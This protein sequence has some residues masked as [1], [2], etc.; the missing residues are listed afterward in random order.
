MQLFGLLSVLASL[1]FHPSGY[2]WDVGKSS[3]D[4]VSVEIS[5]H[6]FA[7]PFTYDASSKNWYMSG[8]TIPVKRSRSSVILNP[9][10]RQKFGFMFNKKRMKSNNFDVSILLHLDS[11][12]PEILNSSSPEPPV[13]QTFGIWFSTKADVAGLMEEH[14]NSVFKA[15]TSKSPASFT[16]VL[17]SAQFDKMTIVPKHFAGVGAVVSASD[18]KYQKEFSAT[19]VHADGSEK[20]EGLRSFPDASSAHLFNTTKNSGNSYKKYYLSYMRLRLLVRPDSV[21]LRIQDGLDWRTV[22]KKEGIDTKIGPDGGYIGITSWTGTSGG[23]P[24]GIR[25]SSV[26][27]NS[28]DFRTLASDPGNVA[29]DLFSNEGLS[30]ERL[31]SED[32]FMTRKDQLAILEKLEKVVDKYR[33]SSVPLLSVL[34]RQVTSLQSS[35]TRIESV[36]QVLGKEVASVFKSSGNH[37][38]DLS[39]V[40]A[41]FESIH[42]VLNQSRSEQDEIVHH[43]RQKKRLIDSTN[44]ADRH[45]GYFEK[46]LASQNEELGEILSSSDSMTLWLLLG[47][48]GCT[49]GMGLFFYVRL[50][51]FAKKAHIF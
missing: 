15:A 25:I 42:K 4:D 43:A 46:R 19:I 51:A 6:S 18:A 16:S 27:V 31:V 47:V 20:F 50:N 44:S 29:V 13:D 2:F 22:V 23:S 24:Y 35:T 28:Y 38:A 36:V 11:P 10:L 1:A 14:K 8:S 9:P 3:P 30:L 26:R 33:Q 32:G 48:I 21:E 17:K 45:V 40:V 39:S 41:Q 7:S 5:S 37:T 12:P 34:N 49:V